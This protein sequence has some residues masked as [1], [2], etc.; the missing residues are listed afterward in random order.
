MATQIKDTTQS[1]GAGPS[2][3]KPIPPRPKTKSRPTPIP[4][5]IPTLPPIAYLGP[6]TPTVQVQPP[7]RVGTLQPDVELGVY[8]TPDHL[9]LGSGPSSPKADG[10]FA[11]RGSAGSII[12]SKVADVG[13]SFFLA[14]S[15]WRTDIVTFCCHVRMDP[16]L[17]NARITHIQARKSRR[18]PFLH[19]YIL[20]FFTAARNQRFVL[21]ID[22][23]GKVGSTS[24]GWREGIAPNTAI[25]EVGVY[26]VQDAQ[27]GI[28]SP[29]GAW[30]AMDGRW[31]SYPIATL[32]TWESE[33]GSGECVS[34]HVQT[35]AIHSGPGPQLKDVSRL[36][37]A[38]LLEMPAYHLTTTN[39]YFMTRTSLLLFQR[40]YPKAFACH[41]GPMSGELVSGSDLA[42]PVWAGLLKWYLP[43][44]VFFVLAY[45]PPV[46]IFHVVIARLMDCRGLQECYQYPA[47]S[48]PRELLAMRMALHSIVDVPLPVGLL[49]SYMT[50]LEGRMNDL[51]MR[52]S[53]QFLGDDAQARREG[54]PLPTQPFGALIDGAWSTLIAWCLLGAGFSAFLFLSLLARYGTLILFAMILVVGVWFNFE[55]GDSRVGLDE[56]VDEIFALPTPSPRPPE[57]GSEDTEAGLQQALDGLGL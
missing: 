13:E 25:Q 21:R 20:V 46:V 19:E 18:P 42:E 17:G 6:R 31:G 30:L 50:A 55:F 11:R 1:S 16:V 53:V 38:I 52:L 5:P 40:C 47:N 4:V 45:V 23:L 15:I 56:G 43:F 29:D 2:Q 57:N 44:V 27:V 51:I 48:L 32:A 10:I 35:M 8:L 28:D 54:P 36:L 26:H 39:C 37:E 7:S 34:H 3:P 41:F 9:S 12:I 22:R 14:N 24:A 49:H 33:K